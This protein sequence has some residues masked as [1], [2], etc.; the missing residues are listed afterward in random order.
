[1]IEN[2]ANYASAKA[3][4]NSYTK[5]KKALN[6]TVVSFTEAVQASHFTVIDCK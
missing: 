6:C 4:L 1:M 3:L 2:A 5:I